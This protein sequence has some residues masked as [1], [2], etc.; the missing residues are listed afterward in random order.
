MTKNYV[1]CG[2]CA[3]I[4]FDAKL[5]NVTIVEQSEFFQTTR[6][7]IAQLSELA[8]FFIAETIR[9]SNGTT[10]IPDS[11]AKYTDDEEPEEELQR[12]YYSGDAGVV[13]YI[14]TLRKWIKCTDH[15][16]NNPCPYNSAFTTRI[17]R[18]TMH[19]PPK[20]LKEVLQYQDY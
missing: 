15:D 14:D 3:E 13:K 2:K 17:S 5:N 7:A 11:V 9:S 16:K 4:C 18:T 6:E 19:I 10:G 1:I 8:I 20:K 12:A